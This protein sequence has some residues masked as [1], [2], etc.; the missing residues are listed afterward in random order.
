MVLLAGATARSARAQAKLFDVHGAILAGGMTGRGAA[1]DLFQQTEGA[2]FAAELGVR[3]LVMDFSMRFQQMVN[4]GGSGG[5]LLSAM[6]GPSLEIPVKRGGR[7]AQG[8]QKPPEVVIRPGLAAG[9]VFGTLLPVKAPLS[10]DQLAGK[11]LLT[12]ARFGVERMFGPI[13]GV[14][15]EV[16]GG[17]HYLLGASGAANGNDYSSGWQLGGFA[18]LAFH[19]GL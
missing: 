9:L 10:N 14:G 11:G 17:Y 1:T 15:A 12:M 2:A 13:L 7:D 3:V 8:K 6:L 5:T 16:E 19:L 18:T 4:S